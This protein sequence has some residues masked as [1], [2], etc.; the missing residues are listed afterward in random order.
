MTDFCSAGG[1]TVKGECDI[2]ATPSSASTVLATGAFLIIPTITFYNANGSSC[3]T[4]CTGT[5]SVLPTHGLTWSSLSNT[6]FAWTPVYFSN[7]SALS[8]T[9]HILLYGM[10]GPSGRQF[11]AA[12]PP[13]ADAHLFTS[14]FAQADYHQASPYPINYQYYDILGLTIKN[15]TAQPITEFALSLPGPYAAN[16][17][18]EYVA[19]DNQSSGKWAVSA[20]CANANLSAAWVC[21]TAQGANNVPAN[22]TTTIYFEETTTP[23]SFGY[24]DVLVQALQPQN[25][26]ITA[27]NA[28]VQVPVGPSN[29]YDVDSLAMALYSLNSSYMATSFA[30]GTAGAGT[31]PTLTLNVTNTTTADDPF[32]DYVDSVIVAVPTTLTITGNPTPTTAGWS[33]LGKQTVGGFT[34]Y[35]FGVCAGQF[36]TADGPPAT[37]PLTSPAAA[38]PQCTAA[39]EQNSLAP[40]GSLAVPFVFS[41][42]PAGSPSFNMYAHG[43]NGD[44]WTLAKP[45]SLNVSSASA[46]AG[47]SAAGG[48]P[49]A[50]AVTAN[51]VPQIGGDA[52]PTFGN[53]YTYSIKNT[54][55]ANITSMTITVP[56]TDTS[57]NNATDSSGQTWVLTAAPTLAGNV[58]GCTV[59]SSSSASTSGTNGAINIGGGSCA[60]K[61]GDTMQVK[62]TA[63]GPSSENDTYQWTTTLN[64]SSTTAGE[65]W[66]GDTDIKVVLSIGLNMVIDPNN[67]GPGGSTPVISCGTCGFSGTTVDVGNVNNNSS[68]TFTDIARASVYITSATT[69]TWSLSVQASSNPVNSTGAPAHELQT[70]VDSGNSSQAAGI[71]FDQTAYAVVPTASSLLLANGTS[72]TSRSTP[73]DV[74]QDFKVSIGNENIVPQTATLTYTLVAN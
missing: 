67:P 34:N 50:T 37:T 66:L 64:P 28:S 70:A 1:V 2:I 40:A 54:G 69:V 19:I 11:S 8:G 62:I 25:F 4:S 72:I 5:T 45:F 33:Y 27:D 44:G 63:K 41:N 26:F 30:P 3:S 32:P 60:F 38:L 46:S 49:A 15:N 58:D 9:A 56:G 17:T 47:F 55:S 16:N 74:L 31:S 39:Q 21:F 18:L 68:G 43:A 6:S 53:A 42:L 65:T 12:P 36:V 59:T 51:T 71:T 73:Y 57:G 7:G 29:P 13:A 35:W 24:S 48:Y 23:T 61:P 52:D 20:P 10:N 14:R 22:G